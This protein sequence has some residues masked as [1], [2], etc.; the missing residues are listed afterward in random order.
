MVYDGF[1]VDSN[2]LCVDSNYPGLPYKL[3]NAHGC[4]IPFEKQASDTVAVQACGLALSFA[5]KLLATF[6]H[7]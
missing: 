7:Q 4:N 2:G 5:C 6:L 3:A 1:C